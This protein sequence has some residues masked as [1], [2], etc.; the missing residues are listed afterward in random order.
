LQERLRGS[1]GQTLIRVAG[2]YRIIPL[3]LVEETYKMVEAHFNE[4]TEAG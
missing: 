3:M 1:F 4:K 2:W